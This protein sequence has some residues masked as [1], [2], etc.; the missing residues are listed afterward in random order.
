MLRGDNCLKLC[1]QILRNSL[2][3]MRLTTMAI[4]AG[5]G[6]FDVAM[7]VT[8]AISRDVKAKSCNYYW[9]LRTIPILNWLS[10]EMSPFRQKNLKCIMQGAIVGRILYLNAVDVSSSAR[11][12]VGP[13]PTKK[14][15]P[16]EQ[17]GAN[18][19]AEREKAGLSQEALAHIAGLHRTFVGS[20]ERGER[21]ISIDN[22]AKLARAL[23]LELSDLTRM[24]VARKNKSH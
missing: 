6:G 18:L 14:K 24:D 5:R 13:M 19:K 16:R 12:H 4:S 17:F 2:L 10:K 1:F 21:N 23:G 20:V 8:P 7:A 9:L 11:N 22:M 15:N 3:N